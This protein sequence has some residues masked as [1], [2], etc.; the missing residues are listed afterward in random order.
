MNKKKSTKTNYLKKMD[1]TLISSVFIMVI[2]GLI[3]VF[4]ASAPTANLNQGNPY[5]FVTRQAMYAV[6]G[7]ALMLFMANFDYHKIEK[8]ALPLL[9]FSFVLLFAVYIPGLG[10]ER[11]N[12]RRWVEIG[13]LSLQPS[14]VAKVGVIVYFAYSLSMIKDEIAKFWTGL[15]R[16][17]VILGIFAAVLIKEPHFSGTMVIVATAA[18]MLIV[19]GAKIKHFM[20]LAIP[21]VLLIAVAIIQEPYRLARWTAFL[22]PFADS[23]DTGYQIVQSLYAVGSGGVFGMGLGNSHQK[24]LFIPEPQNDFIFS[25]ICEELGWFGAVAVMALFTLLIWKGYRIAQE[26]PDTFGALLAVGITTLV[27][28]QE[29]INIAVVTSVAPVTGMALPFFSAGGTSLVILMGCI[30]ILLNISAQV[31]RSK[32]DIRSK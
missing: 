11:N 30:G 24:F 17:I 12:A 23:S 28:V 13:G 14:E 29:V 9:I 5:H 6:V 31:V 26:A 22:N 32:P 18:V 7:L 19:A 25:I 27:A 8:Y 10:V 4:S 3:M 16:Y 20:W 1:M 2:F 21:F 15:F